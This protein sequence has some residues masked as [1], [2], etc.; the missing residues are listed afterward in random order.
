MPP[1]FG[2]F[3]FQSKK[4]QSPS[5]PLTSNDQRK[6]P[7][8]AIKTQPVRISPAEI[9][10]TDL[11]LLWE[12]LSEK[13]VLIPLGEISGLK[14][15]RASLLATELAARAPQLFEAFP[16]ESLRIPLVL[17]RVIAQVEALLQPV[18]Q[19]LDVERSF[20]TPFS[21]ATR[22]DDAKFAARQRE[23]TRVNLDSKPKIGTL[24][25]I[26]PSEYPPP[27][28][29]PENRPEIPLEFLREQTT[30]PPKARSPIKDVEAD[31]VNG[32]PSF[33]SQA[34]IFTDVVPEPITILP[35]QEEQ[36]AA[37]DPPAS[38]KSDPSS[39]SL[40]TKTGSQSG[41]TQAGHLSPEPVPKGP[42]KTEPP[43]APTPFFDPLPE[44]SRNRIAQ[45]RL[46]ELFLTDEYMDGRTVAEH[47]GR[48]PK[49]KGVVILLGPD[50][51][52]GGNL[53]EHFNAEAVTQIPSLFELLVRF[54]GQLAGETLESVTLH[55]SLPFS[56]SK[57]GRV[58][59]LVAHT[60]RNMVPGL[61]ERL[62]VTAK[63]LN[64][65]YNN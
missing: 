37:S 21:Q 43:I 56:I 51:V 29:T 65:L 19:A 45:E 8:E 7:F 44:A 63:I 47:I 23:K 36:P 18:E 5:S 30:Q 41:E 13:E 33:V 59:I 25:P 2:T 1:K 50:R 32:P 58:H 15:G 39:P 55:S 9:G 17:S 62:V 38:A 40:S 52:I 14:E 24:F 42:D 20:D 49:V 64:D 10:Q 22:E 11:H 54:T 48:L 57:A 53:D 16:A 34:A 26:D 35:L 46:Q 27:E 3:L 6:D 61:R 28:L 60:G 4:K 12:L 31:G